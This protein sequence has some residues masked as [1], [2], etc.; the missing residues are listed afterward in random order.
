MASPFPGMDPYLESSWGDVHHALITYAREKLQEILP[1]DLRARVEERVFV[2]SAAS[3]ERGI[4]PDIRSVE[5]SRRKR[6]RLPAARSVAVAETLRIPLPDEPVTQGYIE[7]IDL[8][9]GRRVVTVIEV[10]SPA[11]KAPGPGQE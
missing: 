5:R 4:Y 3:P 8:A 7:I 6:R 9:T 2:E 10:L 11:N 1:G